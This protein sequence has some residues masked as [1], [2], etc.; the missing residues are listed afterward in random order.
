MVYTKAGEQGGWATHPDGI[1]NLHLLCPTLPCTSQL[2]HHYSPTKH[3]L[4]YQI[5]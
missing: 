5:Q 2:D 4:Q 1:P 3:I